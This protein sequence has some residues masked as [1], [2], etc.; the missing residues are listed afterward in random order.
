MSLSA[1]DYDRVALFDL[2][3]SLADYDLAMRR[4]LRLLCAPDEP[5]ITTATKSSST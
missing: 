3:G 2:D 4:D 5:A 1:A